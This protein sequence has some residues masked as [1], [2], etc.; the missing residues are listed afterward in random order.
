MIT[1]FYCI[2]MIMTEETM[3]KVPAGTKKHGYGTG[4]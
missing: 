1:E 4:A 3:K 2:F